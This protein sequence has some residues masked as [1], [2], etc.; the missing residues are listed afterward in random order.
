MGGKGTFGPGM[1]W[2]PNVVGELDGVWAVNRVSGALPPLHGCVKR[3]H[4]SRGTTEFP[5]FPGM[6]F[7]VRGL[8]LRYRGPL[9]LMVDKLERRNGGYFGRATILGR[10]FGQFTLRRLDVGQAL[11]EQL[12]KH[13]DEAHA[14]EQNVLRM[15][16][17]M[18]STTDDPEILDALEHHKMQTHG[19][20]DRMAAR[21]RAH[22]TSPSA[23]KQVGGVLGALA[24]MPLDLVRGE[25]SGRNARDAFAT[26]HLEIAS[27]ELL[28]RIAARAGDE[29]TAEAATEI[30]KEEKHMADLI[31]QNWDKFAELS[32]KEEGI[33]V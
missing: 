17:G 22:D 12:V 30:I 1:R 19:H 4:G 5:R 16:D 13:I 18:I 8:E 26:E 29:E 32:L 24:K 28:R 20:L 23:V 7:E 27:Y 10:E 6:P 31:S 11:E 15:L 14:M 2:N 25:K 9:G 21:L 3:I 33:T